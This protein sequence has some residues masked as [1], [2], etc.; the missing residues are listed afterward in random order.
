M[1]QFARFCDQC[2]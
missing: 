1:E 2:K